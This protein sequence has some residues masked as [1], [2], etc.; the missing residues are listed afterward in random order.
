MHEVFL[1][2]KIS[3]ISPMK[4]KVISASLPSTCLNED[5]I[6]HKYIFSSCLFCMVVCSYIACVHIN[7]SRH[8]K[9]LMCLKYIIILLCNFPVWFKRTEHD[10]ILVMRIGLSQKCVYEKSEAQPRFFDDEHEDARKKNKHLILE[11]SAKICT[12]QIIS[13]MSIIQH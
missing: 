9:E 1:G 8:L 4:K 13:K 6:F 12:L 10:V 11:V 2:Q 5:Y 7:R 3:T